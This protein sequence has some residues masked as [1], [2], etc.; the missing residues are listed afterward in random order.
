MIYHEVL[1]DYTSL[2]D[3]QHSINAWVKLGFLVK[4]VRWRTNS[5]NPEYDVNGENYN[6][7]I[8]AAINKLQEQI[9]EAHK[10]G[11]FTEVLTPTQLAL[12]IKNIDEK[13][14]TNFYNKYLNQLEQ[15]D[16]YMADKD[17][18]QKPI[19][20]TQEK[21][22]EDTKEKSPNDNELITIGPRGVT[23]TQMLPAIQKYVDSGDTVKLRTLKLVYPEVFESSRKY[24]PKK[25]C[26]Y[27]R[28]QNI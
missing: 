28:R 6:G 17:F 11:N 8:R 25:T 7:F 26:V 18:F 2:E 15:L 24:L 22:V 21:V 5:Q 9:T 16:K 10:T 20:I 1:L 27:L 19:I 14:N 12:Y 13:E 3:L 23:N 4:N